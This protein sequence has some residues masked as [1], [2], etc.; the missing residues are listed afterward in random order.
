MAHASHMSVV[1]EGVAIF[2]MTVRAMSSNGLF[3]KQRLTNIQANVVMRKHA[4]LSG[5]E[6]AEKCAELPSGLPSPVDNKSDARRVGSRLDTDACSA[7]S[8]RKLD[9]KQNPT[10]ST[11]SGEGTGARSVREYNCKLNRHHHRLHGWMEGRG[12]CGCARVALLR[13]I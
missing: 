5:A 7:C 10:N 13:N 4:G 8:T 11:R 3:K 9:E 2:V 6:K 1:A 12:P